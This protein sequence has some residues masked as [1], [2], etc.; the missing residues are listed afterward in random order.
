M[1][2]EL[3]AQFKAQ[4]EDRRNIL[5]GQLQSIGSRTD[6]EAIDFEAKFPDY[7]DSMEDNATEVADYTKNLSLER[8]LEKEL[9]DVESALK[10]IA[11]GSYGICVHCNKEIELERLKIRPASSSCVECKKKLKNQV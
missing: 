11:D 1:E 10:K 4:L 7:G 8:D 9:H 5:V 6:G 3:I 2:K